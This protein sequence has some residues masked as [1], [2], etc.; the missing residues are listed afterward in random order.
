MTLHFLM[1]LPRLFMISLD[2]TLRYLNKLISIGFYIGWT[3]NDILSLT[4]CGIN[5]LSLKCLAYVG[6]CCSKGFFLALF[7]LLWMSSPCLC[8]CKVPKT[9]EHISLSSTFLDWSSPFLWFSLMSK[10]LSGSILDWSSSWLCLYLW[11]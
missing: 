9:I 11:W 1:Y 4:S 5:L 10:L 6:S 2:M 3:P 7:Y 8:I